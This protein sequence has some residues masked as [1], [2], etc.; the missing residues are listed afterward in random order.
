MAS[1]L[2]IGGT[3]FMGYFAVEEALRRGHEVT[4]FNR[5]KSAPKVFPPAEK[6][7]GDRDID[8][9]QLHGRHW[10]AVIDTAGYI[11]RTVRATVQQLADSVDCYLFISS[12]SVY[13]DPPLPDHDE[14]SV[15]QTLSD[16]T[17]EDNSFETYGGRKVLCEQAVMAALPGRYTIVR[18]CVIVGPRDPTNRFDYWL[19]RTAEGGEVLAPHRPDYPIQ[20]IDARDAGEWLIRLVE[21]KTT[22]IYN[23]LGPAQPLTFGQFLDSCKAVSGSNAT[24]TWVDET[25]LLAHDIQPWSELP[26]WATEAGVTHNQASNKRALAAGLTFRPLSETIADTLAWVRANPEIVQARQTALSRD[27]ERAVLAAWHKQHS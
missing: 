25:F 1:I 21:S 23:A 27:K 20:Y 14:D 8:I 24:F 6:I 2:F 4:L 9:S 5:G 22:G 26:L 3:R 18:P 19:S 10:D 16:P 11:P 7:I 17:I 13:Q 12:I 15:L